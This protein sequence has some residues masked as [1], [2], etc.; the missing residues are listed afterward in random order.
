M[1]SLASTFARWG[2]PPTPVTVSAEAREF[3]TDTLGEPNPR[4]SVPLAEVVTPESRLTAAQLSALTEIVTDSGVS[5][6]S[7][8]RL[9]H[10]AGCSLTDYLKQRSGDA[11]NPPDAVVRPASHEQ[12]R[13]LLS[14]CSNHGIS[15][16][17]YGGGTSVTGGV[18]RADTK[19][20]AVAIGF[21]RM[22]QM[23]SIDEVSMTVTV[24]PGI[25]GPVLERI[26]AT[27]GLTWGHLPQSWERATIGGYIATR[28]AG[29]AST[30]YGRSDEMVEWLR[31]ATPMGE[32]ELGRAPKSAAGPDLRQLFIGSEGAFGVIT[33]ITLR[34]RHLPA[35]TKY[36]GLMFPDYASGVAAFRE[37]AQARLTADVM[38]LSDAD[39]T[40]ATLAMSGPKGRQG[41]LFGKY[42]DVRKVSGG[43]M[44]ILGWETQSRIALTARRRAAWSILKRHGAATLGSSVGQSWKKHR[45]DGPYLRDE[46]LDRG[47]VVETLETATHWTTIDQLRSAVK[48]ALVGALET[49]TGHPYVMSHVSHVYE[50]GGSLYFTV[51][52]P[53]AADPIAQWASAKQAATDAIVANAGTVTHHHAVGRDHAAWLEDEIGIEGMRILRAVKAAVDPEQVMNPGVLLPMA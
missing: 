27:R 23:L 38:R 14:F 29:Q 9:A 13:E 32:L 39:E 47:Y 31:V 51:L 37:L 50:T 52:V 11:S 16:V 30:G 20:L 21:D 36:E 25:T 17:P 53:A 40:H 19:A 3:L 42:L 43:C 46:L 12:V 45:F 10:A 18:S 26:L 6:T 7:S 5:V 15:V 35:I 44:S 41:D 2:T 1:P 22:A 33:E 48:N 4:P 34:I 8:D 28:S 24:Q 49:E